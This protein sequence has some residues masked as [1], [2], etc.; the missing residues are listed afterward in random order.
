MSHAAGPHTRLITIDR[1]PNGPRLY[2]HGL[3]IHHGLTG[4]V[5]MAMSLLV[6][7]SP[8][9]RAVRACALA[10]IAE[11]GHDFPWRLIDPPLLAAEILGA[12]RGPARPY[13][14]R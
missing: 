2:L 12:R 7:P 9:R 10:M 11:D 3:R 6:P 4:S 5:L 14:P 13:S 8:R 1:H